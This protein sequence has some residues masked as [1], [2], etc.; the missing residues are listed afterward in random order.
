[1]HSR[2]I[3]ISDS[4]ETLV[5]ESSICSGKSKSKSNL[6][7]VNRRDLVKSAGLAFAGAAFVPQLLRAGESVSPVMQRLSTYMS[8]ARGR[9]LPAEVLEKAKRHTLDTFGAMIS[10]SEL[11]PGRSAL[12][13]ARAY[14]GEKVATVAAS[15]IVCG[16]IEAALTNGLLAHSDETDDSHGPSQ[17]HPGCSIVPATLAAGEQFAI[18]GAQFLRA[19]AL[20]YDVGTRVAMTMGGRDIELKTHKSSH[21]IAG[22]FGS[23][24]AAGC[25]ASLSAQQM[26][27]LLSYAAQQAAGTAAWQRDPD[28]I[29]KGFDFA[30][31]PARNGVTAAILVQSG[32]T[33]VDDIFSGPDNYFQAYAPQAD[34]AGLIDKL[35][36]QH[37][38]ARTN[39]KKWTVG[40]PIQAPLDA[41]FN[42]QKK[43]DFKPEQVQK[44][45]VRLA[46]SQAS[47]VNGR[48]IVDINLQ[49]LMAVMLIDKTVS[50]RSTH[51]TARM[52]D[53]AILR[54]RAKIQLAGDEDLQKLMP[55][56]VA[57]VEVTLADGTQLSDRVE[58]VRGTVENPMSREEVVDKVRDLI[59]PVI[60]LSNG[61][62]LI[63]TVLSLEKVKDIRELRP[64]LQKG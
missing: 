62:K 64:L 32:S 26:R 16:P 47:I 9:E 38:V 58:D 36:E 30:G 21:N 48:E 27:W 25:A 45:V 50:F 56:R 23:A 6:P 17:S 2:R 61:N 3:L 1:L 34:P 59:A 33:G 51:D 11:P 57:I 10:G 20:G 41:L 14:G 63:E 54:E 12:K 15:N 5:R 49:H 8:E 40:S 60:G 43:H 18:G 55:T 39:I 42:I 4:R 24:A 22:T 46:S 29:E 35:G 37:E 7:G 28:H 53:P 31:G 44:V 19:M 13:F 52:Q